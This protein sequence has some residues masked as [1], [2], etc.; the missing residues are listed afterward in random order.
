MGNLLEQMKKEVRS[1]AAGENVD[2]SENT[3]Q[4]IAMQTIHTMTNLVLE[5]KE[6][7]E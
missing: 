3:I 4:F 5:E 1:Y 2:L 6:R 7:A